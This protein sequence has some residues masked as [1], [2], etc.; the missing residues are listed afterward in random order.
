MSSVR[1][2]FSSKGGSSSTVFFKELTLALITFEALY[3]HI[4]KKVLRATGSIAH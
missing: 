2:S 3:R 1:I 4:Y